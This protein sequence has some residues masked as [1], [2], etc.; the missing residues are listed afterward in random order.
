MQLI[1]VKNVSLNFGTQIVL[2]NVNLEISNGQRICRIGR[3]GTGKSSL[4]KILEGSV[5]PDSGEVIVHNN[6]I[7]ASMI[8]EVPNDMQGS[9]A[10]GLLQ[11]LG[12]LGDYLIED[13]QTLV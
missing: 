3:N 2:D 5:I 11:G 1:S 9:I 8:Q 4:L 10:D 13:Q 7:V 12:T 6:A